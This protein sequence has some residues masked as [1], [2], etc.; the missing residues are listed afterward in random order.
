MSISYRASA[1]VS[2]NCAVS[3]DILADVPGQIGSE[4]GVYET[5]NWKAL[6]AGLEGERDREKIYETVLVL[7]DVLAQCKEEL[8]KDPSRKTECDE[9]ER[10][11]ESLYDVKVQK[12]G[13]PDPM[14]R[15]SK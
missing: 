8:E 14:G 1:D 9:I 5:S 7:E 15:L 13:F 11:I 3:H 6:L 12:L 2:Y 10:A 4:M